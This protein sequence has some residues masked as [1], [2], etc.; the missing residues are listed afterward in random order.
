MNVVPIERMSAAATWERRA[1]A[2]CDGRKAERDGRSRSG[3]LLEHPVARVD[4]EPAGGAGKEE[5][6]DH[7]HGR[8][9]I[10]ATG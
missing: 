1:A 8:I 9:P 4:H 6:A 10:A 7:E 2:G 3:V 5:T